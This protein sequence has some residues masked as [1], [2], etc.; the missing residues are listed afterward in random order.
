[1]TR[2]PL[3]LQLVRCPFDDQ[4]YRSEESGKIYELYFAYLLK[5]STTQ[6]LSGTVSLKEWGE[7]THKT[8]EIFTDFDAICKEIEVNTDLVAGENKGICDEPINLKIYS[9]RVVDLTLVDL[10]GLTKVPVGD[11]P[12]DIESQI[13]KLIFKYIES[14]NCIILAVTVAN[15]DMATSEAL[16]FA[17]EVDPMG[18]RT[19]A[20]LTKIGK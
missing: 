18:L 1:M 12:A 11:Q 13:H 10:P 6:L 4:K 5:S 7:F 9:D 17:K 3:V 19:F 8:G 16:K 2:R 20:V 15:A 14:V